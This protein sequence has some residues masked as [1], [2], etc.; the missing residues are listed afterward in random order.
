MGNKLCMVL[1]NFEMNKISSIFII[2]SSEKEFPVFNLG[3][4]GGGAGWRWIATPVK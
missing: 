1:N 2:N 3:G 4:G